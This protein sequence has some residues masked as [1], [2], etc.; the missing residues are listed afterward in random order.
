ML[1]DMLP[2]W[3]AHLVREGFRFGFGFGFGLEITG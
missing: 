1:R 3:A 2:K